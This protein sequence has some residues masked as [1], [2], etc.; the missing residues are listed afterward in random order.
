MLRRWHHTIVADVNAVAG[1]AC[2]TEMRTQI[3]SVR[4]LALRIFPSRNRKLGSRWQVGQMVL[5]GFKSRMGMH[6]DCEVVRLI[7]LSGELEPAWTSWGRH[8]T[9]KKSH[10]V[11][12]IRYYLT[13]TFSVP[14][15]KEVNQE[16][17]WNSTLSYDCN[18]KW[19]LAPV[20]TQS[21]L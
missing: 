16:N 18:Y 2:T 17:E 5:S 15:E 14:L 7:S 9:Q 3:A 21:L 20:W 6:G 8:L 19:Y 11:E 10:E 13:I 12:K 1:V 4:Y